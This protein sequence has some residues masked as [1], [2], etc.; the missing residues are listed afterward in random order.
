MAREAGA[1]P[2]A[3]R[4]MRA[5]MRQILATTKEVLLWAC[6]FATEEMS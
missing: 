2:Y 1:S 5:H 3:E 6:S 4:G